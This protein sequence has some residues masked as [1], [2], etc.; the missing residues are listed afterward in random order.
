MVSDKNKKNSLTQVSSLPLAGTGK[1]IGLSTYLQLLQIG[2]DFRINYLLKQTLSSMIYIVDDD[3]N[4]RDGLLLLLN[5]AGFECDAFVSAEEFL[6][7]YQNSYN[8]LLILDMHLTG[9]SGSVLLDQLKMQEINLPVIIITGYDENG[10]RN[11]AKKYG[12]LA[13]LRKPVDG[14]ALID[15][16][17]FN[18]LIN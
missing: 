18:T 13:Y 8:D 1:F 7:N 17:K 3:H 12:A 15:L 2:I 5:S 4:V 6:D 9:M 14:T 16:I 11:S 10:N